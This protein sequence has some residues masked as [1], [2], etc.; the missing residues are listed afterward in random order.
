MGCADF[1][2]GEMQGDNRESADQFGPQGTQIISTLCY[3]TTLNGA[4]IA[5]AIVHLCEKLDA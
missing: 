5:I 2:S 1:S 4:D 3:G